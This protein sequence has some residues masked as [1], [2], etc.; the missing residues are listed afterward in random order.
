MRLRTLV[1]TVIAV[2]AAIGFSTAVPASAQTACTVTGVGGTY[3]PTAAT[4]SLSLG[5]VAPGAQIQVTGRCCAANSLVTLDFRP[6]PVVVLGTTQTDVS[7]NFATTVTIPTNATPGSH[8]IVA[9]GTNC[10]ATAAVNVLGATLTQGPTGALPRTGNSF[11][12]PF[13]IAGLMLV[14]IGA[15]AVAATRR[16]RTA[17]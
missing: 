10:N 7:G 8:T 4:I 5:Q 11:T 17:A 12:I 16:K 9:S 15:S 1:V 13:A 6:E 2:A 3:V 14:L